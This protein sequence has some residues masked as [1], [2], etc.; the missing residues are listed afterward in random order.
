MNAAPTKPYDE[1][2]RL[3]A[4]ALVRQRADTASMMAKPG[5]GRVLILARRALALAETV[6]GQVRDLVPPL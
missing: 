2:R 5:G 6:I 3:I 1:A 4:D